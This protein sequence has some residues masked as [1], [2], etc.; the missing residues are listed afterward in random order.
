MLGKV[1]VKK[2]L[3]CLSSLWRGAVLRGASFCIGEDSLPSLVEKMYKSSKPWANQ[4]PE[5][6]DVAQ[7]HVGVGVAMYY[8]HPTEGLKFVLVEPNGEN[9]GK[10]QILGGFMDFA[11]SETEV[12]LENQK[13]I[14]S[15]SKDPEQKL[16]ALLREIDEELC[17]EFGPLFS[18]INPNRFVQ[19][20]EKTTVVETFDEKTKE[21]RREAQ[22]VFG[23]GLELTQKEYEYLEDLSDWQEEA[24]VIY[25]LRNE[26]K[27]VRV[28]SAEE[29]FDNPDMLA[30]AG[31]LSLFKR[32]DAFV[33]LPSAEEK[34]AFF[35]GGASL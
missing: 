27:A 1:D 15:G 3:G 23:Y 11:V 24:P 4:S 30:Q 20:D 18:G 7:P 29:I 16:E 35:M 17:G 13:V 12:D 34:L 6:K 19:F 25:S 9:E 31:L 10:V 22:M 26:I 32:I 8:N 33:K 28:V 5:I 2:G 21:V 14:I